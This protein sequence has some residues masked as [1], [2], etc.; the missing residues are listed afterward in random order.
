MNSFDHGSDVAVLEDRAPAL[1]RSGYPSTHHGPAQAVGP[2]HPVGE[3]HPKRRIDRTQEAAT[4][5][6]FLPRL[7]GVDVRGPE[8]ADVRESGREQRVLGPLL[9]CRRQLGHEY[10]GQAVSLCPGHGSQPASPN[11]VHALEAVAPGSFHFIGG[12]V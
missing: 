10:K 2:Y 4:A 9:A 8:K 3:K 5:V 11:V 12:P 7:L 6:R 1:P